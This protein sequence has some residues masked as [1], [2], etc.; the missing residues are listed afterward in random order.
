M[1]RGLTAI[2]EKHHGVRILEEAI[3][4][5]VRLSHRYIPARQ[6]PDKSLS[7]LDT[8]CARV[9][10]EQN[11]IPPAVEDCRRQIDHLN[12]ELGILDR[13]GMLGVSHAERVTARQHELEEATAR[14]AELE[15]RWEVERKQ[16]SEIRTL[17]QKIEATY[18]AEKEKAK[19]TG[20]GAPFR[21]SPELAAMQ[22]ELESRT[23]DLRKVQGES[24]LMQV[25]VDEQTIAEVVAGWTGIPVGKMMTNEIQTIF[26][27]R[28]RL[29][30][31]VIGQLY[32]LEAITQRIRTARAN[33]TDPRR[34]IGVFMLVGPSGVGKTETALALADALYGGER[35]LI[36]INMSEYQEAHTVSGLKGSPPGYVGYGEG[37]VLTEAVRRRPYSVVLLDEVEKAHPDVLELFF[38]VFDKGTLE[39]GEGRVIDF[40]NTIILLTSNVGT[41]TI[42][43]LCKD[44]ETIPTPEVLAEAIRPDLLAAKS[45][46]GVQ[47]FKQAFLG[48]LI[49]IP[50]FPISDS[51]MRSI[52]KL[53]L[54]HIARR[55]RENHNAQFSYSDD[56]IECIASRCHE[57]ESGAR[58]VDHILT[59]TLLPEISQEI[60]ARMVQ[61]QKLSRVHVTVDEKAGFQ[62]ALE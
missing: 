27:L 35:N 11:S 15:A 20:E 60:L 12:V 36:T 31:R 59:R 47:I 54:G 6:L 13:E 33:L 57:V 24:S 44:P 18:T 37:G 41:D 16:V 26:N 39:D 14:L 34:P 21:P 61:G 23:K 10:I 1:M 38:Q 3:E 53:Q 50:Y 9:A 29:E 17:A 22:A 28:S 2:L 56:L 58:N 46:R 25:S 5:A 19:T 51:V 7:L 42:M 49:I 55:L 52:I 32:A 4:S 45:E 43:K 48:R 8:A 30:E 40:K 62:Y